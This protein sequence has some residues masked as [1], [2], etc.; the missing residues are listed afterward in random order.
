MDAQIALNFIL[1]LIQSCKSE[2][3]NKESLTSP[4]HWNRGENP[5]PEPFCVGL[6][7]AA[8]HILHSFEV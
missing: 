8:I 5:A 3:K 4:N 2:S 6:K 1:A 7:P